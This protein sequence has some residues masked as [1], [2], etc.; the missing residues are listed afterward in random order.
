MRVRPPDLLA[1]GAA[2]CRGAR[3]ARA[4]A[5]GAREL[6]LRVPGAPDH[7]EPGPGGPAEG[8]AQLR[9]RDRRRPARGLGSAARPRSW[10]ASTLAGELAL[11]GSIRPMPGTLAMAEAATGLGARR[12][13]SP[14][15]TGRRPRSPQG[16]RVVPLER[17][18][19]LSPARDRGRAAG[20]TAVRAEPERRRASRARP[21]R[22]ARPAVPAR[23][24]RDRRRRR[25]QPADHRAA[26]SRQVARGPAPALDPAAAQSL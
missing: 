11:D 24:A 26:R 16:P 22:P 18:E 12:S 23:R 10:T 17:L 25:A 9:P 2:G 14:R 15:R 4:G 3:V 19:Q 1:G 13:S 7:R 8:R 21:R 5:L 20:S 6:R